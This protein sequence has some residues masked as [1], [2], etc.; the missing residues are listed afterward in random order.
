[1]NTGNINLNE[2]VKFKVIDIGFISKKESKKI[3][4]NTTYKCYETGSVQD[5]C[6]KGEKNTQRVYHLSKL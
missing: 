5:C 4:E 1:M 3:K 2:I 6:D